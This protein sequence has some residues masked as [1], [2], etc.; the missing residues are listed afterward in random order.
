MVANS[1]AKRRSGW[2]QPVG[3]VVVF[4]EPRQAPSSALINAILEYADIQHPLGGGR[5]IL[6]L[7]PRRMKDPVIKS[8]LGRE[9]KRLA[10]VSVLWDEEEGALIRVFDDAAEPEALDAFEPEDDPSELDTF[11]LTEAALAYIARHKSRK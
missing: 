1:Y 9:T 2:I 5:V 10:Q 11:E 6:R 8:T 4:R 7:S 3:P